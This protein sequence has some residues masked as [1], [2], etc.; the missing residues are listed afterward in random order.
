MKRVVI[1]LILLFLSCSLAVSATAPLLVDNADLLSQSEEDTLLASLQ[2]TSQSLD[3]DVV[4]VTVDSLEGKTAQAYADD[5]F[6][7]HG[8]GPDGVLL[9]I[10]MSEREWHIST[11][12]AAIDLISNHEVMQIG[13][14]IVT[15]LGS[16]SYLNAFLTFCTEVRD[17]ATR[18]SQ[19]T[20]TE[21]DP[22]G[23]IV[24]VGLG[25]VTGL[26]TVLI[27]KGQLKSVRSQ[28]AAANYV[29]PNSFALTGSHDIFLFQNTTRTPRPQNNGGSGTHMGSSGRSHG[30]G[31]GR[32]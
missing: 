11:T 17:A 28:N 7:Y 8:Y 21:K 13:D 18:S 5:Y 30:G 2:T 25:I 4:I 31:G 26:V 3:M 22:I 6:D 19:S 29:V 24:C 32:F 27:L 15:Y 12:G 1:F 10:S 14:R 23:W 20:A 9:L 16:G